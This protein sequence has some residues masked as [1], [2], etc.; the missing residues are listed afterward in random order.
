M[1]FDVGETDFKQTPVYRRGFN[2]VRLLGQNHNIIIFWGQIWNEKGIC[3]EML[4]NVRMGVGVF[5]VGTWFLQK[6]SW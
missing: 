4:Q 2:T 1:F 3:L 5:S 6:M